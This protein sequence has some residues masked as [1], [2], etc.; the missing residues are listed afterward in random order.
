MV[1]GHAMSSELA[2]RKSAGPAPNA[3][4]YAADSRSCFTMVLLWCVL[5]LMLRPAA[6]VTLWSDPGSTLVFNNGAGRDVLGGAVKRDDFSNDTLYFKFHI[7][8]QSDSS[9]EEYFAALELYEGDAERIGI[10]NA[11]KA[12][13]YSAFVKQTA[14]NSLDATSGYIDLRSSALEPSNSGATLNYELPRRGSERTIIF[15]VQFVAGGDDLVT[16]W[17]NPDLSAGAN[18]VS[19]PE[20]L[21]TR[22]NANASFDELRLRHGGNGPGWVFSDLAIATSFSDFVDTSSSKSVATTTDAGTGLQR[23]GFQSWRREPGMPRNSIRALTQTRDG[24]LWLGGDDSVARF[25]GVRFSTFDLSPF[26]HGNRAEAMLGD[27]RGDLWVGTSAGLLLRVKDRFIQITTNDGLPTNNITALAEDGSGSLWIGTADG[28]AIWKDGK[29]QPVPGTEALRKRY[30]SALCRDA[31]GA[32]WIGV[33]DCG[34]FH[35]KAGLLEQLSEPAMDSLLR[36]PHCLLSD[37]SNHLW[38]GARDDSVLCH[39]NG[40][41]RQ[42]RIPG[43]SAAPYITSLAEQPDGTIWAGSASEGLFEFK[44]G[45]MTGLNTDAGLPDNR[46]T[47]LFT[48][49]DG[50]LWISSD[51]ELSHLRRN[52]LM[53][54]GQNDGLGFG[55]VQGLAEVSPGT[56]WAVKAGDGLYR[57]DGRS[58]GRLTAAGLA[59]RDPALGPILVT[60]DGGCWVATTNGL[61]LYRDPQAMADES[62]LFG[63]TNSTITSLAEG[64]SNIIWAGTREGGL[65]RL[66]RGHWSR[67]AS[68]STTGPITAIIAETN[69]GLWI[70]T[71]ADG[72]LQWNGSIQAHYTKTNGLQSQVIRTLYQDARG[73]LWIGTAGGGVARLRDRRIANFTSKE[74]FPEN[75]VS[76]ILED[77]ANRLWLGGDHGIFSVE[78]RDLEST[79][80]IPRAIFQSP[81]RD[82]GAPDPCSTGFCPAGLKTSSGSLWFSTQKGVVIAEPPRLLGRVRT[83][84]M[85]LEEVLVDGVAAP[86][87][88]DP[89]A[90]TTS[91]STNPPAEAT[92]HVPPGTHQLEIH[93]TSPQ[94]ESSDQLR[95]RYKLEGLDA[96]WIDA[97]DRRTAFYN[98]VP[99]GDYRFHVAANNGGEAW[100]EAESGLSLSVSRHFWQRWWVIALA[101]MGLLVGVASSVRYVEKR[102]AQRRLKRLEQERA[103][104][105]E[106]HRIAQDLHDELGAKLCHISF[107]SEHAKRNGH[108]QEALREQIHSIADE[109]RGLL[110]TLDEIVW[111]VNPQNDT[112]EHLASYINQYAQN[113]FRNT[114]IECE[115]DMPAQFASHPVSSQ[116][117]HH[118]FLAVHEAFTNILKHSG[119]TR[120]RLA[121]SHTNDQFEIRVEDNGHG[122]EANG[123]NGD[124]RSPAGSEDGLRNMR[125]RLESVGGQCRIQSS[126]GGGTSISFLLPIIAPNEPQVKS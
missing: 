119:A 14:T 115:L 122:F 44:R 61:L 5:F 105:R 98:Y 124:L 125:H 10:G 78:K 28:I 100:S 79:S 102:E 43:H 75:T 90:V 19:Q 60:R 111:A 21:T 2:L 87:I 80:V 118:L 114:G 62:R 116:A 13:A 97:G 18:E 121:M 83:P 50:G 120:A 69:G 66:Q 32:I 47:A 24:Y 99:P 82:R 49:R 59:S 92:V 101:A 126:P 68:L 1:V 26:G 55:A 107:L 34:V 73:E 123:R 96:D 109:S 56:I 51:A 30:I 54:I 11:L 94:F 25:D 86:K 35:F 72:I 8:P 104:E 41:W 6:A 81:A 95:F 31:A 93:Y 29:I 58:F 37:A 106:R 85:L 3:S 77:D 27:S 70:G 38:V 36:Q 22:F 64:L 16:V 9:T 12:W 112:L 91:S 4:R 71:A 113:Y 48:D 67:A 15:K 53:T 46:V 88:V 17:L 40:Q 65:W 74:G 103:L 89:A 84:V 7:D 110:H 63:L 76:Q 20:S 117:R 33:W 23:F 52:R 39:E 45:K 57:W 42:F 108:A